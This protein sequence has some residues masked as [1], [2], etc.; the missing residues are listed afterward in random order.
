MARRRSEKGR[1]PT[2]D[3]VKDWSDLSDYLNTEGVNPTPLEKYMAFRLAEHFIEFVP[4]AK[5]DLPENWKVDGRSY[6]VA[7]FLL[8][9]YQIIIEVDGKQHNIGDRPEKDRNRDNVLAALGF[10]F[11]HFNWD[12]VFQNN[13]GWD[14]F[15]L[16]ESAMSVSN[17]RDAAS[18]NQGVQSV[19]KEKHEVKK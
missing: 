10:T 12:E 9:S 19:G 17:G 18:F 3:L 2:F 14:I 7:D 8:P 4:Q 11:F 5:I 16:L 1:V 13:P 6:F 15:H